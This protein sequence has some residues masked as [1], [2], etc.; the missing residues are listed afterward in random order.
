MAE[1]HEPVAGW[2]VNDGKE[3]DLDG[4]IRAWSGWPF[5]AFQGIGGDYSSVMQVELANGQHIIVRAK[6]SAS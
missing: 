4:G 2:Y 5:S 6:R 3:Y 1:P